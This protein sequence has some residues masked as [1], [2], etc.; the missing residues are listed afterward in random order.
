VAPST[1]GGGGAL[2]LPRKGASS[3]ST[4][5][6]LQASRLGRAS[7]IYDSLEEGDHDDATRHTDFR[8]VK[9][10]MILGLTTRG[11]E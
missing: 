8:F 2:T 3:S 7:A 11:I 10:L 9:F 4:A 5:V 6:P 1:T